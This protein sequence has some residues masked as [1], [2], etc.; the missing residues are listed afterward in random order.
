MGTGSF[1]GGKERSGRD[2]DPSP[3]SSAVGHER[4]ELY[5]Y[6]THN[7]DGAFNTSNARLNPICHLLAL[8]AANHILHVSR[9]RVKQD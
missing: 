5:L 3:P 9:I 7:R 1:P 8:L 4:V 2:P 6:S